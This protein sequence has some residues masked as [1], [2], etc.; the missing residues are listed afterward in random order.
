M[1][2]GTLSNAGNVH[3]GFVDNAFNNG[4]NEG[5]LANKVG[6]TISYAVDLG[7]ASF[8]VDAIGAK[9]DEKTAG[10]KDID[11]TQFG[12]TVN[13]GE[14]GKVGMAYVD[15]LPETT[16]GLTHMDNKKSTMIAGKYNIGGMGFHLGYGQTKW[17]TDSDAAWQAEVPRTATNPGKEAG[18]HDALKGDDLLEKKKKTTFFGISGGL[19]DT[20]VT[21]GLQVRSNK[22]TTSMVTD[23]YADRLA[24]YKKQDM[25][26]TTGAEE[27]APLGTPIVA[28]PK[29]ADFN[30]NVDGTGNIRQVGQAI[31]TADN[32]DYSNFDA[33]SD[34]DEPQGTKDRARGMSTSTTK[35]T[36]WVISLSRSLGGG[37]AVH[38]E[39][40]NKDD[41]DAKNATI[42]TLQV[43]F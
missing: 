14:A 6:N 28:D 39:H 22:A 21:F 15:H 19:G 24:A 32:A 23:S 18:Y 35:N 30:L 40:V 26:H 43:D 11:S 3:A 36:P 13:I 25:D 41:D 5:H 8:Q 16:A 33:S 37:A 34:F 12:A 42:L 20:G 17:D 4:S 9:A 10:D 1:S 29:V 27:T 31:S 38:L 2:I 7:A